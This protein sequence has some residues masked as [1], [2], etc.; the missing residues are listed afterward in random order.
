MKKIQRKDEER[1]REKERMGEMNDLPCAEPLIAKPASVC[2][3]RAVV[4][5]NFPPHPPL[6]SK[7]AP[8]CF[9]VIIS[10]Y[11]HPSQNLT[12]HPHTHTAY[13]VSLSQLLHERLTL[14]RRRCYFSCASVSF[15]VFFLRFKLHMQESLSLNLHIFPIS[16]CFSTSPYS[17]Q[18]CCV[19]LSHIISV[20]VGS[21]NLLLVAL[22]LSQ[23]REQL[24]HAFLRIYVCMQNVS[25]DFFLQDLV[26]HKLGCAFSHV[27]ATLTSGCQNLHN[28][29]RII[30]TQE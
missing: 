3:Q 6:R 11:A 13:A 28:L 16:A 10:P 21:L 1:E 18:A 25:C 7:R 22:S 27:Q 9:L 29:S 20:S 4:C 14:C 12:I 19:F 5:R 2:T 26:A 23:F 8:L 17:A 15:L 24:L 30:C